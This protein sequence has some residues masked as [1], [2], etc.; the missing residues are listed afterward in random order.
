MLRLGRTATKEGNEE[1]MGFYVILGSP[2]R[3]KKENPNFNNW[4]YFFQQIS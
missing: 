1:T 4:M 2:H 3:E